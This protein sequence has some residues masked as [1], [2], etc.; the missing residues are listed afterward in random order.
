MSRL[1]LWLWIPSLHLRCPIG[2]PSH[3][4]VQPY[5]F[6]QPYQSA[7]LR[8]TSWP[9]AAKSPACDKYGLVSVPT[10]RLFL[11]VGSRTA[12][13]SVPGGQYGRREREGSSMTSS[14]VPPGLRPERL[15]RLVR[16]SVA[17]CRIDLRGATVLTEAATGAYAVTPVVAALGGAGH[18][19]AVT[20]GT[21]YGSVEEVAAQTGALAAIA[22]VR[23]RIQIHTE[24]TPD[25]VGG[26]DVVTNSGHLRPL[27]ARV[28]GWMRPDTAV[29]LMF[30]AW[31]IDLGRD[32][33]DLAA[34]RARGVRFAGTNERHPAVDVFS[35][36]GPMAVKLLVD[37]AVAVR[38]SRLVVLCDNPFRSYL[39][40]G[41]SAAGAAV[42]HV[43]RLGDARLSDDVDAVVV[44]L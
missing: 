38:G 10:S 15:L 19:D 31:E 30:E 3:R 22:G 28:V 4:P 2:L 12:T 21:R 32:D 13:T 9:V 17:E 34:M 23:D 39:V 25:L 18:V 44:A 6:A 5:Q 14:A 8:P 29:P 24:V 42:D 27:D 11:P 41:L 33:V 20:R 43:E 16:R 26:A 35:F 1:P 36:L 40:D 37:A 7:Q